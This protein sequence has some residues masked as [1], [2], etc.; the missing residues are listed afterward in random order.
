MKE[1]NGEVGMCMGGNEWFIPER[2]KLVVDHA[3][4]TSS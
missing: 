3:L 2:V 1:R 4:M